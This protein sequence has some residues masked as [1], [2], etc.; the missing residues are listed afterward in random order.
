MAQAP[1]F[2]QKPQNDALRKLTASILSRGGGRIN[3]VGDGISSAGHSLAGAILAYKEKADADEKKAAY[4]ATMDRALKA[5]RPWVNPD[6]GQNPALVK[7]L[8]A[9]PPSGNPLPEGARYMKPGE[10]AKGT[11]GPDA[12][13][14]VLAQNPDTAGMGMQVAF[15]EAQRKQALADALAVQKAKP[16]TYSAPVAGLGSDGKPA[17]MR[18]SS[19]G[20]MQPVSGFTPPAKDTSTSQQHNYEYARK[21]GFTGDFP[22]YIAQ[23]RKTIARDPQVAAL[24]RKGYEIGDDGKVNF[25]VGGP[26]DPEVIKRQADAEI[27]AKKK[28][29]A[30]EPMPAAALKMQ[31]EHIEAIGIADGISVDMGAIVGMI[32]DEKIDLGLWKNWESRGRNF[33]G[34]STEESK[35]FATFK[36]TLEKM[37][38]DSL[39]L[40]KGI[41]TEGD[42]QRA[43]NELFESISD[44][45]VVI[46]RLEEIRA[47]NERAVTQR[48][49]QVTQLRKNYGRGPLEGRPK[50]KSVLGTAGKAGWTIKKVGD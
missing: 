48:N 8:Q 22:A 11:G 28:G 23:T 13:A 32:A 46:Q 16:T 1:T 31:D 50:P 38:N 2:I 20:G 3:N 39:R 9:M 33:A 49:F 14:S 47:I 24:A 30:S 15:G 35:N 40:N 25:I 36:S 43:W 4:A 34:M 41:Q 17:F 18:P 26:A 19:D 42:A 5:S 45:G 44:P 29:I 27:E 7:S 37:R 12:V 21:N 10:V 6:Q